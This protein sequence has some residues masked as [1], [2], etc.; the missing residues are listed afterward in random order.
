[1]IELKNV[2]KIYNLTGEVFTALDNISLKIGDG[3]FIAIVGPSGCG[4]STL[5]HIIGLL[6]E[7]TRGQVNINNQNTSSLSDDRLSQL[8]NKY[9]GFVF[10]QFNLINKLNV[11]EN[12]LLPTEYIR[13]GSHEDP[14]KKAIALM[15]RFN[16]RDKDAA[17]PNKLS[18]GQQQRVAIARALVNNPK[19]ILADEPT[20]NLDSKTG[21]R[22]LSLLNELNKKDGLTVVLVT[23]DLKIAA[24]AKRRIEMLDGKIIKDK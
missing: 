13:H 14:R 6:D 21:F 18:G 15:E 3:E 19:I 23:H 16:I 10:Q 24:S 11:E 22:I 4:K 8:R 9:L 17:Y 12:I 2:S 5:M 7:P 1:M 20:G